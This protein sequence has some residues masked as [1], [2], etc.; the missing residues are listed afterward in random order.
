MVELRFG[1]LPERHPFLE[2]LR[3]LT[4]WTFKFIGWMVI[5]AT[6]YI[7]WERTGNRW[8]LAA[9]I[10]TEILPACFV[11]SFL[12]WLSALERPK[13]ATNQQAKPER[14]LRRLWSRSRRVVF[15]VVSFVVW[16]SCVFAAQLA[17][18]EFATAILD[19]QKSVPK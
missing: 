5:S 16:W 4:D 8:L 17:V 18:Q 9:A 19:L 3:P 2:I 10:I 11:Y 12:Q 13:K 1:N 14:W 6:I 15:L 7:G